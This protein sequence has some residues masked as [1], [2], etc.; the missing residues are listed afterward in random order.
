MKKI[1]SKRGKEEIE[2]KASE[3]EKERKQN[4]IWETKAK[5][6]AVYRKKTRLRKLTCMQQPQIISYP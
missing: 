1:Q 6:C 4:L 2:A 3:K 5:G